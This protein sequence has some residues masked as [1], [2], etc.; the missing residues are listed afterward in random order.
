MWKSQRTSII[1]AHIYIILPMKYLFYFLVLLFF[2]KCQNE[3][4]T[5]SHKEAETS[6]LLPQGYWRGALAIN[7]QEEIPFTFEIKGD[8]IFFLN[9]D[10]RI[11]AKLEQEGVDFVVQM[12]VFD[13]EF[14]FVKQNDSSLLGKW[15]NYAK[16]DNYTMDFG[17]TYQNQ[18]R[19]RV[20][21]DSNR[22]HL[23][24]GKWETEFS[25]NTPNEYKAIG[26]FE[27]TNE[28]V[29]GTFITETGDYRFLEGGIH[30]DSMILSCFDGSHALLFK[31]K[32]KEDSMKGKFFSG[33]HYHE[34]WR[35]FRN[36][37]FELS[38]P[39]SITRAKIGVDLEFTLPTINGDSLHY[40]NA[41]YSDKVVIIQVMGSWCPN[42]MDETSLFTEFYKAYQDKGLEVIAIA[43]EKPEK[44][45]DKVERV[46]ELKE[47]FGAKYDFVIGGNASKLE[48]EKVLP[49]LDTI[50]SFPTAIFIDKNGAIRKIHTGFYGPGTGTY[51]V[52]YVASTK[53]FIEKL[54][55]E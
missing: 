29:T 17:A 38:N 8:S 28:S 18:T 54:L 27:E 1:F 26:L 35:A 19:F 4:K 2:V 40:P 50:V 22:K 39:D 20:P 6:Y 14:R 53:R 46:K 5:E 7:E 48:A 21:H 30:N 52:K 10:E 51:Y 11:G 3:S 12:P 23:I 15:H 24:D 36:E 33:I 37:S 42:C 45:E 13:S 44:F 32:I 47:H 25:P 34:P 41:D 31:A 43:F 16:G 49:A 9:S 55:S